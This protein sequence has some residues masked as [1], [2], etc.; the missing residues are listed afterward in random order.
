MGRMA[1]AERPQKP[2]T[3]CGRTMTWRRAWARDWESVRYCSDSCRRSGVTATDRALERS[4]TDLLAS[5]AAT[6]TVCPSE[7]ARAVGGEDWRKLMEPAR[8]A[9]R[10]LVAAGEVEITQQGQVVDPSTAKGPIR[11]RR[12]PLRGAAP[13]L[14]Q[15]LVLLGIGGSQLGCWR[16]RRTRISTRGPSSSTSRPRS[17]WRTSRSGS[18]RSACGSSSRPATRRSASSSRFQPLTGCWSRSTSSSRTSTPD[19][20]PELL[21]QSAQAPVI[22][23]RPP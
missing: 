17:R 23:A 10:R 5:R 13:I 21:T 19:R 18:G 4:I 2:C 6:A 22:G 9:A 1:G 16:T 7:A 15:R 12:A 14:R 20:R 8:A 3:V 11:I